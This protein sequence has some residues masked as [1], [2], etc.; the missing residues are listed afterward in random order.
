[1]T[2]WEKMLRQQ[3]VLLLGFRLLLSLDLVHG[4]SSLLGCCSHACSFFTGTVPL[5]QHCC[6]LC[7]R[8]SLCLLMNLHIQSDRCT[9]HSKKA[10]AR[11]KERIVSNKESS[12]SRRAKFLFLFVKDIK[13]DT[14]SQL[15]LIKSATTE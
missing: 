1:M 7:L 12:A 5:L 15:F 14:A 4:L 10:K 11:D 3:F 2:V 9:K 8:L 6:C 13:P